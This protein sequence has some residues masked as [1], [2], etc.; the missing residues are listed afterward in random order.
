MY[1]EHSESKIISFIFS[2]FDQ[3]F[4]LIEIKILGI[5]TSSSLRKS[6]KVEWNFDIIAK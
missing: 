3:L 2:R 6:E 4:F 5:R 1:N